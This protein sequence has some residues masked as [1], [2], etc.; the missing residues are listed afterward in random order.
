MT[1]PNPHVGICPG[2]LTIYVH[3]QACSQVFIVAIFVI[4][5]KLM[6]AECPSNGEEINKM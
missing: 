4:A 1:H 6:E 2:E 5:K 3:T